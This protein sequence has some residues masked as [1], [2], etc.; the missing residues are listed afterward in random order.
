MSFDLDLPF[1]YGCSFDFISN[2]SVIQRLYSKEYMF[3]RNPS[4][5]TYESDENSRRLF[6]VTSSSGESS[7]RASLISDEN[8]LILCKLLTSFLL[9]TFIKIPLFDKWYF[10]MDKPYLFFENQDPSVSPNY[11]FIFDFE[12][13]FDIHLNIQWMNKHYHY[14]FYYI[15][16]YLLVIF[17]VQAFM[18][19]RSRF[20][21]RKLLA[22][23]NILLATFSILGMSRTL[24]E[25]VHVLTKFGFAYS[26]CNPSYMFEKVTAF[27]GWMFCYSKIPELFDTLF[28][29]LRKQ[30]LIFL[31][32]YHHITVLLFTWYANIYQVAAGRWYV[33]M[34]YFVHSWMYTY[35]ALKS[36]RIKTPRIF[37]LII[38]FLQ[39]LQM[40]FGFYITYF[41][42]VTIHKGE[43]CNQKTNIAIS[44]LLMYGS[45]FVLF[46]RFF[47]Y[48]Y[49]S[50]PNKAKKSV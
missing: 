2:P 1:L 26:V 19:N 8:V 24:P 11:S 27:W 31:H 9:L 7:D 49:L 13:N 44:G 42:Y 16:L 50:P 6:A 46:A 48:S 39:I 3:P 17:G 4:Y 32:W 37:A 47:Y 33:A 30:P 5:A 22:A 36:L 38:T 12:R 25:L 43:P 18:K 35:F 29:V 28:I 14:V 40:I 20:E 23:W 15:G 34:N 21:V 10:S 45:Y 41:S